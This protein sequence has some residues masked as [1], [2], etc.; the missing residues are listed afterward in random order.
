M[1]DSYLPWWLGALALASAA[2]IHWKSAGTLLGVSGIFA[3]LLGAPASGPTDAGAST[4]SPPWTARLIFVLALAAG[5]LLGRLLIKGAWQ[6]TFAP[7]EA[8]TRLFG[9]GGRGYLTLF[10]G[11]LLVGVGTRLARGCTSGHG[12]NGCARLQ[13][14][15]LLNTALF[16]GT[17][18]GISLLLGRLS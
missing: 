18:V 15:S 6:P 8:W 11:G 2:L 17:A 10:V 16:L 4:A 7:S 14:P 1:F 9:E 5:G 13:R 3:G 12:L